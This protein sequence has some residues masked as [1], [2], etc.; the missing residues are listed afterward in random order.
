[1]EFNK[2][3]ILLA[4]ASARRAY[5]LNQNGYEFRIHP[6]RI[7]ELVPEGMPL[8]SVPMELARQKGLAVK[9]ELRTNEILLS[10]DTVVISENEI[11]GKPKGKKDARHMLQQ[12]SDK[13]HQVIS[14]V[15]LCDANGK[16]V[17]FSALT[18]VTFDVLLEREIDYYIKHYKPVDKAGSYGIQEWLGMCRV[19][20]ISGSYSN[21]VGLPM[22]ELYKN[23]TQHF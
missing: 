18:E 22:Y 10:C 7:Q 5:L 3:P 23:L 17:L 4:S 12:L 20:S 14:G 9:G 6:S 16:E 11:L 15:Y 2:H 21:V 8:A 1:M 19:K 13:T